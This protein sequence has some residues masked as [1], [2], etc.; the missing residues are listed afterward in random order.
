MVLSMQSFKRGMPLLPAAKH[1]R[2]DTEIDAGEVYGLKRWVRFEPARRVWMGQ[3]GV[4]EGLVGSWGIG[5]CFKL[6]VKHLKSRRNHSISEISKTLRG[7]EA[8]SNKKKTGLAE[9]AA[10]QLVIS[11]GFEQAGSRK[12]CLAEYVKVLCARLGF[13]INTYAPGPNIFTRFWMHV[14]GIR[15]MCYHICSRFLK[16]SQSFLDDDL[17][18]GD[19]RI[20]WMVRPWCPTNASF[21]GRSLKELMSVLLNSKSELNCGEANNNIIYP[22][23]SFYLYV[24]I[25]LY[26]RQWLIITDSYMC[27]DLV[28]KR[29]K[30]W[31]NLVIWRLL[32]KPGLGED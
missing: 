7:G 13:D 21:P 15:S 6:E 24:C 18:V 22:S 27:I 11:L 16:Q 9:P 4:I 28:W 14:V 20:P 2:A 1:E 10:L 12:F 3:S 8:S 25:I 23:P 32:F 5:V 29:A 19:L 17:F 30:I 31:P 26:L